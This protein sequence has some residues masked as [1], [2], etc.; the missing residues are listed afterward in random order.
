MAM[1][2]PRDRVA[3]ETGTAGMDRVIVAA[4]AFEHFPYGIVLV[5]AD[6]TP[7]HHNQRARA[8]LGSAAAL[9]DPGHRGALC[10]VVGC[11]SEGAL[12]HVCLFERALQADEPLPE[13][14][15]DLP[16]G[17]A[18]AA[19]WVTASRLRPGS[20]CVVVELRPAVAHDRR[21]RTEP[22]WVGT[23]RIRISALGR[24]EVSS[25]EGPIGGRWLEQR[26]GQLLKYLVTER[27][28]SV[29]GDEIAETLWP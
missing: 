3:V 17:A 23:R 9:L 26:T 18:V 22:H 5:D 28:R 19:A 1:V 12:E 24:T 13:I 10:A 25:A 21:R 4:D 7:V 6:G 29:Y 16:A 14:R 11:R 27:H 8:L 15:V 2:E 20:G